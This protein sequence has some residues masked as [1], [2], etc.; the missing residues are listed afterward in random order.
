[1]L[2]YREYPAHLLRQHLPKLSLKT[3]HVAHQCRL[4]VRGENKGVLRG[5]RFVLISALPELEMFR[6]RK[7]AGEA[8]QLDR[9]GV[10]LR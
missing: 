3:R 2:A 8:R 4:A 7:N 9:E 6:S 5:E 10:L 1:M